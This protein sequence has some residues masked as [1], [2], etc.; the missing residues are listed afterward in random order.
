MKLYKNLILFCLAAR[1]PIYSHLSE[2]LAGLPVIR[3][4][5]MESSF[6]EKFNKHQDNQSSA[7]FYFQNA[8]RWLAMRLDWIIAIYFIGY[9]LAAFLLPDNGRLKKHILYNNGMV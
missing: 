7:W 2:T 6:I 4:F 5:K 9:I 8:Q 1:S 3:A